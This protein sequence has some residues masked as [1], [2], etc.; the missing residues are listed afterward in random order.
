M[1][2]SCICSKTGSLIIAT[3]VSKRYF[4]G[5]VT[6]PHTKVRSAFVRECDSP[7]KEKHPTYQVSLLR[8]LRS[9]QVPKCILL[10]MHPSG[11]SCT[12]SGSL[13]SLAVVGVHELISGICVCLFEQ[14]NSF[15]KRLFSKTKTWGGLSLSDS[16]KDALNAL[17]WRHPARG[18][19]TQR[20]GFTWARSGRVRGKLT[21]ER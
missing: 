3:L 13:A 16:P 5:K 21:R 2:E 7:K 18:R 8:V 15:A 19:C 4:R 17:E 12:P 1:P 10:V 20:L 6:A 14:T 11:S 9:L